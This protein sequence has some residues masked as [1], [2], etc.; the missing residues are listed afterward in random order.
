MND[1]D[2]SYSKR[3][4]NPGFTIGF[5]GGLVMI[6]ISLAVFFMNGADTDGDVLVW[7]IQLV[8]YFFLGRIA[9]SQMAEMQQDSFEPTRGIVGAGVGAPLVAGI[10]MWIYII[11][12]GVVRDA[13]GMYIVIEPVSFCGWVIIDV[14]LALGIGGI[15]GKTVQDR[16]GANPYDSGNF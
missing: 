7:L 6:V 16:Y 9:A 14:L 2:D 13:M 4:H 5:I 10:M 11:L 8:V 1:F 15:A 12:R 3:R